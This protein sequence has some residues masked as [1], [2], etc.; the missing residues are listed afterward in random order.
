MGT[1]VVYLYI[2]LWNSYECK[3][4]F[5]EYVDSLSDFCSFGFYKSV[6]EE[7]SIRDWTSLGFMFSTIVLYQ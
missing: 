1:L 3:S 5:F 4:Y 7:H 2:N 6:F